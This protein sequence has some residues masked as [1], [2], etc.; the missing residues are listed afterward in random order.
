MSNILKKVISGI[1]GFDEIAHGGIP[2]GRTTLISGASGSGKTVFSAQFLYKGVI[3]H[4]ENCVFV[5]FEERPGDIIKNMKGFGWDVGKL[6]K[7]KKW[8]FVDASPGY[9][10]KIESGQYDLGAFMAR[11]EYAI[12]KVGAKRVAIDSVSTIFTHF[13]NVTKGC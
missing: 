3:D 12:E 13:K 8:A 5:T 7:E 9:A 1:G 6:E 11:V 2:K 10:D 4:R